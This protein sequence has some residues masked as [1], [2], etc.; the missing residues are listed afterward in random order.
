MA[1]AVSKYWVK[2]HLSLTADVSINKSK[3][4]N[5]ESVSDKSTPI[6]HDKVALSHSSLSVKY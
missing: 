6:L 4:W 5:K 1:E 2:F 3:H